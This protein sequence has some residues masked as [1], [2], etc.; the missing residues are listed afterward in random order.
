MRFAAI[1]G[2]VLLW[3]ILLFAF[4]NAG[5]PWLLGV[6]GGLL[7]YFT[8]LRFREEHSALRLAW[9][10]TPFQGIQGPGFTP[11][12]IDALG[13]LFPD[14]SRAA[15]LNFAEVVLRW[16][17]GSGCL[18]AIR[19]QS[20]A[21]PVA[22]PATIDTPW[23]RIEGIDHPVGCRL[24][25]GERG[26]PELLE[27]FCGG[28]RTVEIDWARVAYSETNERRESTIPK[29]RPLFDI[30]RIIAAMAFAQQSEA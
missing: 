15:S 1:A 9:S 28:E 29:T 26:G 7:A 5:V 11:L 3:F 30:D 19:G 8:Y 10:S 21:P 4:G 13:A 17:T 20:G 14:K 18:T 2:A 24:W 16:N 23:F 25:P 6:Y 12:E 27:F 22:Q